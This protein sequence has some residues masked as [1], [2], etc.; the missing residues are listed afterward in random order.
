[1]LVKRC[2]ECGGSMKGKRPQAVYCTVS[3]R[4]Q[5]EMERRRQRIA[6]EHAEDGRRSDGFYRLECQRIPCENWFSAKRRDA[7]YCSA[8]CR[9]MASLSSIAM[10][11]GRRR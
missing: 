2:Q 10:G 9:K 7:Q 5:A 4:R 11:L 1:M 6:R 8:R 3:C